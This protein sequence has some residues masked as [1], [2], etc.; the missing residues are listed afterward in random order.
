MQS[1][2]P[3]FKTWHSV[4]SH[5]LY[6]RLEDDA[7]DDD[8][9]LVGETE[10]QFLQDGYAFLLMKPN[11]DTVAPKLRRVIDFLEKRDLKEIQDLYQGYLNEPDQSNLEE[12]AALIQQLIDKGTEFQKRYPTAS[13]QHDTINRWI[14]YIITKQQNIAYYETWRAVLAAYNR[15]NLP[16]PHEVDDDS[17]F[18]RKKSAGEV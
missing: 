11:N 3:P 6:E 14:S 7:Y 5:A 16:V 18:P 8:K 17:T 12:G 10:T 15:N 4:V 1:F 2:T 9:D 13:K